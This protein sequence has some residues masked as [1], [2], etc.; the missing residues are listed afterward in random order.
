MKHIYEFEN[1]MPTK[2]AD[3]VDLCNELIGESEIWRINKNSIISNPPS[4]TISVDDEIEQDAQFDAFESDPSDIF[5]YIKKEETE[6]MEYKGTLAHE[7]THAVQFI[8]NGGELDLF[9][10]DITR[11]LS[12]LSDSDVWENLMLGIYLSDPIEEEAWESEIPW[13]VPETLRAMTEWMG[14]FNPSDYANR[15][16]ELNFEPNDFNFE[17]ADEL[18][19]LWVSIYK[20]YH[21][22]KK[23]DPVILRLLKSDLVEFLEYFNEKFKNFHRRISPKLN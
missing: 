23:T 12:G 9:I 1:F 5:I 19:D 17:S 13:F 2:D 10:G 3:F 11:E 7:L 18:P 20:N 15:L 16:R 8:A 14:R 4:L 22:N 21:E 6:D